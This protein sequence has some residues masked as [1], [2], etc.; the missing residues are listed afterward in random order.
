MMHKLIVRLYLEKVNKFKY[1][2]NLKLLILTMP[3]YLVAI[4]CMSTIV[5][6]FS[7]TLNGRTF[8]VAMGQAVPLI[9]LT[10]SNVTLDKGIPKFYKCIEDEI[11]ASKNVNDDPYF[12]KEPTKDEVFK[13]YGATFMN[14]GGTK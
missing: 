3:R 10:S 11:D 7:I 5:V 1:I 6:A 4:F 13:C 12:K 2:K 14:S 9:P 8:N